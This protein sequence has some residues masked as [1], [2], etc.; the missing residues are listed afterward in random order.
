MPQLLQQRRIL[1]RLRQRDD[2]PLLNQPLPL[3]PPLARR[4]RPTLQRQPLNLGRNHHDLL[5]LRHARDG[6]RLVAL[7]LLLPPPR[8]I[9]RR[10]LAVQRL[11]RDAARGRHGLERVA[12]KE[13]DDARLRLRG[14]RH[15]GQ[16]ARV[17]ARD[18]GA[19]GLV[20]DDEADVAHVVR[21]GGRDGRGDVGAELDLLDVREV[22][23]LKGRD[24][25]EVP[26][27]AAEVEGCV[28]EQEDDFFKGGGAD[29][30]WD[31]RGEEGPAADELFGFVGDDALLA[32]FD[33]L[34]AHVLHRD[35][36]VLDHHVG[37]E[38]F[39]DHRG[40]VAEEEVDGGLEEEVVEH[41]GYSVSRYQ[42]AEIHVLRTR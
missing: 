6:A 40:D 8:G 1:P 13:A 32:H 18:V 25:V 26:V 5:N 10:R 20:L 2:I 42:D 39:K 41:A 17:D 23:A 38:F 35:G 37:F 31:G 19:A 34:L 28:G 12:R 24:L 11:E 3:L 30:V 22:D 9:R 14:P 15:G 33:G 7:A 27:E 29:C 36:G 21:L 4:P 16:R